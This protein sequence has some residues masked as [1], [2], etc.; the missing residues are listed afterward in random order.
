MKSTWPTGSTLVGC[1]GWSLPREQNSAFPSSGT[2]LQRYASVFRAVEIN[3][4]FYRSHQTKTYARWAES[5]PE[6]FR[7]AVKMPKTITHIA[8]LKEIEVPLARF[9]AEVNGLR[10]KLGCLLIQLPPSL[11]FEVRTVI[12]FLK[13]IREA[14]AAS[15]VIEP[16]H[17]TWFQQDVDAL[18]KEQRVARVAADPALVPAAAEPGG[19]RGIV[20]H[21]LHG[22]P[23]MYYSPYSPIFLEELAVHL[24]SES[25]SGSETWCIFDNTAS[26]AAMANARQLLNDSEAKTTRARGRSGSKARRSRC[27]E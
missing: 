18:L 16:R 21:R 6:A 24:K 20:Y 5:V 15:L 17:A 9:L 26:G 7:F 11:G 2:H 13:N 25:D 14:S 1:A 22:S 19:W 27:E 23:R 8:R 4:S 12:R 10:A 3:S